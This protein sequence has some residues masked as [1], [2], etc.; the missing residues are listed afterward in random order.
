MVIFYS[1]VSLPE[2]IIPYPS[3]P[4]Y[5]IPFFEIVRIYAYMWSA[6]NDMC[7]Q[8]PCVLNLD[9]PAQFRK[10]PIYIFWYTSNVR[11]GM[12]YRTLNGDPFLVSH[13]RW[14]RWFWASIGCFEFR[15]KNWMMGKSELQTILSPEIFDLFNVFLIFDG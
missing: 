3:P 10:H 6:R 7:E 9:S 1:Y 13:C 4:F 2:G 15:P 5:Q 11:L 12:Q 14:C 8:K